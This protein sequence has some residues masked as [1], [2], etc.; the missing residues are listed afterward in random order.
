MGVLGHSK[1]M[2]TNLVIQILET[3]S[4]L[5]SFKLQ[6]LWNKSYYNFRAELEKKKLS[7]C[8]NTLQLNFDSQTATITSKCILKRSFVH[9]IYPIIFIHSASVFMPRLPD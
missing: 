2:K 9:L 5:G 1:T 8:Q 7:S 4:A 6:L 3:K